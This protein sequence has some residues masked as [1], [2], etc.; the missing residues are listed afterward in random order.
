MNIFEMFDDN[1]PQPTLIDA[2][3]DFLPIAIAHVKLD[4]IPKIK[5]VTSL[6]GTTFGQFDP[7][8]NII[9]AVVTNRSPVDILRTIAHEIVHYKQEQH[10]QLDHESGKTGSPIED[11]ANA[12]AGVIMRLFAEQHPGYLSLPAID[13]STKSGSDNRISEANKITQRLDA[14]CWKGYKKQGTK[15]KGDTKVN[16]CVKV[17]EEFNAE[18]DDEAGMAE[19]N[20]YTLKRAVDSLLDTIEENENLPEWVQ[21]KIA[22]AEMMLVSVRD[23]LVSQEEQGIDPR[24]E[25]TYDGDE[26]FEVYGEMY[27]NQDVQLDEAEYQGRKVSLGKPTRGDVKK[28]KVYVKDPKTGNTKKVNF[29]DPNMRI[30]KSNPTRRKSF[31]ARHNCANPGPRTSARY[32]SCRNW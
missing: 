6:N 32:W 31:R 7:K 8:E 16:N 11:E 23:Y 13:V 10:D 21:E 9:Y 1:T 18:Y 29:G 28:F 5:L 30:K 14:K 17:S 24:I 25:E 3:R 19:R 20:L 22:K 27:Y 2:L 12:E 4:H 15:M 26:F